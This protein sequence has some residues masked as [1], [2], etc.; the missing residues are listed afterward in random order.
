MY[1]KYIEILYNRFTKYFVLFNTGS[2]FKIS[3]IE[4]KVDH[5]LK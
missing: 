2:N 4:T 5:K 3:Y 1:Y